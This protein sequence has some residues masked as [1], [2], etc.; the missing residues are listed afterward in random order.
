[1]SPSVELS[2]P[3]VLTG[4]QVFARAPKV[5]SCQWRRIT[6][7]ISTGLEF[8]YGEDGRLAKIAAN[9]CLALS[10]PELARLIDVVVI[11]AVLLPSGCPRYPRASGLGC[12]QS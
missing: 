2:D 8:E 9:G 12:V 6:L 5:M 7:L 4:Q 3:L 11:W 10:M 1:M